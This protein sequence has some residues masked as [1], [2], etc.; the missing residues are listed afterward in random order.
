MMGRTYAFVSIITCELLRA[1]SARSEKYTIFK[2]GLF[3]NRKMNLATVGSFALLFVVML[4]PAL[5]D[6][7]NVSHLAFSD[8][9]VVIL[10]SLMPLV[11]GELTKVIKRAVIKK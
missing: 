9:D 7:F 11:F 1:Y 8:W 3:S 2:I 6:V 4:V 10:I 5:N